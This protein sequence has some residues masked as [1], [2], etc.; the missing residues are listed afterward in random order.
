M[1]APALKQALEMIRAAARSVGKEA[2]M[3]GDGSALVRDGWRFICL[4]EPTWIL[5]ESLRNNVACCEEAI[6]SEKR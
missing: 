1:D 5:E 3:I 2:W 6:S 4:G